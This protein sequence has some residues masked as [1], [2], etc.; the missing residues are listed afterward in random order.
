MISEALTAEQEEALAQALNAPLY[1]SAWHVPAY[2][3]GDAGDWRIAMCPFHLEHGYVT[4]LWAVSSMP[5]LMR[6]TA[7]AD[8]WEVWMSLTP[9]EI[10]SQ[11]LACVHACGHTVVMGLGMGWVAANIALNPAVQLVTIIERD[12]QVIALFDKSGAL[13]GL[14]EEVHAKLRIIQADALE[15]VPDQP[16]DLLYIDIWR[17]LDEL[18]VM[19]QLRTIQQQVEA[20]MIYFWGQEIKLFKSLGE[21]LD[22]FRDQPP[23][24]LRDHVAASTGLP[25]LVPD[26]G[27]YAEMIATVVA[28]RRAR[29]IR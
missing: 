20:D 24:L 8:G 21:G 3:E 19:A 29:G 2:R 23:Q 7:D 4:G 14:P 18:Q 26:A 27:N 13:D 9:H 6:H 15:W 22:A 10:E 28:V 1:K 5:L 11:E 16:V 12:P 17:D 25:L